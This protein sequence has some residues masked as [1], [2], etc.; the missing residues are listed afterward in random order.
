ME[1]SIMKKL[2]TLAL[3]IAASAA[4]AAPLAGAG[5]MRPAVE[6]SAAVQTVACVRYGRRGWGVY[7]GCFGRPYAPAYVVAAP[8]YAPAPVY[9][10]PPA[11]IRPPR[12]CWIEGAWRPC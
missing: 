1:D 9:V 5:S 12:R 10:A 3:V 6:A 2:L 8:Y 7:G 4:D 11:Y